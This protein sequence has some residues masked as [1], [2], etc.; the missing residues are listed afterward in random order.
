MIGLGHSEDPA[1]VM[2]RYYFASQISLSD[3]DKAAAAA[4]VA[5]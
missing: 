2:S 5:A 1:D 3:K 4:L